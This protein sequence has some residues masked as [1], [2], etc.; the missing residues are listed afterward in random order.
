MTARTSVLPAPTWHGTP[1][2]LQHQ[3]F[4]FLRGH[5]RQQA[6]TRPAQLRRELSYAQSDNRDDR[7][8]LRSYA[9][10][11][12]NHQEKL[13]RLRASVRTYNDEDYLNALE[14]LF[15]LPEVIATRVDRHGA[16]VVLIRPIRSD[17]LD[18][19]D[20]EISFDD[21]VADYNSYIVRSR[22]TQDDVR[23]RNLSM[24]DSFGNNTHLFRV[25]SLTR[26]QFCDF[27]ANLDL[28]GLVRA[29]SEQINEVT[30]SSRALL[31]QTVPGAEPLWDGFVENPLKALKQ[32]QK[33]ALD[34]H[35]LARQI[36]EQERLVAD[37]DRAM[38]DLR[39]RIR[40]NEADIRRM[41][42]EL[43]A[44]EATARRRGEIIDLADARR[45]LRFITHMPGFLGMRFDEDGTAVIHIRTSWVYRDRRY[46]LGDFE[47]WLRPN[48]GN[49]KGYGVVPIHATRLPSGGR[50]TTYFNRYA[51]HRP[52]LNEND[53]FCFGGRSGELGNML[54]DGDFGHFVNI[55]VNCMNSVNNADKPGHAHH[56]P[57][58]PMEEVWRH[59]P[60]TRARRWLARVAI[61][62]S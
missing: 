24:C 33:R 8:Q 13:T 34:R 14:A 50:S 45:T 38:R 9:N 47:L 35:Q 55:A 44:L 39:E 10:E 4:E 29:I 37:Y 2:N 51:S 5:A 15:A 19:G 43:V 61:A 42:A 20:F 21:L 12:R 57:V 31:Q 62:A 7:A 1:A 54:N 3:W 58:I 36:R 23:Y 30:A 60:R 25:D 48:R 28:A 17:S 59:Q 26:Q 18:L 11:S 16:L 32:L 27:Y 22:L 40:Q 52:G 49:H 53:W 41:E 6:Q 56:L 46:D